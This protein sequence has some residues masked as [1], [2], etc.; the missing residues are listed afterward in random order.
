MDSEKLRMVG[1]PDLWQAGHDENPSAFKAI[2]GLS[3]LENALFAKSISEP[4]HKVMR[5][6]AKI[7]A[8]SLDALTTLLLNGYGHD[9]M[10]IARGIF[11]AS[12]TIAYLRT[13]PEEVEDY[14]D[15][16]KILVKRRLDYYD[17]RYPELVQDLPSER[18][19]GIEDRYTAVVGRF[20]RN[21]RIRS[22]WCKYSLFAMAKDVG[23]E[24][25]YH[26]TYSPASGIHHGDI[27]GLLAQAAEGTNDVEVAPSVMW[28]KEAL[29]AGHR[30]MLSIL[31]NYNETATHGMGME[32]EKAKEVFKKAWKLN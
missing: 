25:H 16:R 3:Q 22:S 14:F 12:V 24:D 1:F 17:R 11:E 7:A 23:M 8:N 21:G 15:F 28:T 31:S 9:G 10:K 4:L 30:G 20:T 26:T 19:K 27:W 18:R 29:F 6:L 5:H 2:A 13:H 32:L